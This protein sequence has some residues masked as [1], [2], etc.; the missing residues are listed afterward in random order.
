M[1]QFNAIRFP[2]VCF[3]LVSLTVLSF[4]LTVQAQQTWQAKV[5]AESLGTGRQALAFLPSENLDS[6]RRQCQLDLQLG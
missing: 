3:G 4:T 5:G 6:C 1:K 2:Q